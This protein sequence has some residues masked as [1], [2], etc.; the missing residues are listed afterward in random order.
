MVT[1]FVN[2]GFTQ[3]FIDSIKHTH[4]V[5][6][7]VCGVVERVSAAMY[8]QLIKGVVRRYTKQ[9][10]VG[11]RNYLAMIIVA[12]GFFLS[13]LVNSFTHLVTLVLS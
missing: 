7:F 11:K 13:S 10:V 12:S 2:K 4:N 9:E 5:L 8:R 3:A 6:Y 1:A